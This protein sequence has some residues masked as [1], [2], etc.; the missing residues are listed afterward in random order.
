MSKSFEER[1]NIGLKLAGAFSIL[2]A[3]LMGIGFLGLRRMDQL[4]ANLDAVLGKR[5]AKLQ[6]AREA[7][8][9]STRNSRI[10]TTI[11]LV[12]DKQAI[13]LLR[14]ARA[15]NTGRI[16]EL[17]E[18]LAL[19]CDSEEEKHLLAV[20]NAERTSYVS[21]Y[22]RAL[23]LLVDERRFDAAR[24]IMV[25]EATPALFK[26]HD[27][28][29][30]FMQFEMDQMDRAAR[31]SR[32]RYKEIRAL[33]LLLIFLAVIVAA[34]IAVVMTRTSTREVRAR[35]LAQNDVKRLNSELEQRVVERTQQLAKAEEQVRRTLLQLQE[36]TAELEGV[37]DLLQLLQSC[38]TLEEYRAQVA[39]I[40]PR[41]FPRGALLML[42]TSHDLLDSAAEWGKL[43]LAQAHF[44]LRA[45]G[46]CV[47]VARIMRKQ[48]SPG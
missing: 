31:E 46:R 43:F 21:S 5:W 22:V 2:I 47:G 17:V 3:I 23:H 11:F 7:L 20:V 13:V 18:N 40:L 16:S 30:N 38:V 32:S 1:T 28:W 9:Y 19:Q 44:L 42:N 12:S 34:A 24:R 37:K 27:A 25:N 8:K 33:T 41:F 35:V 29:D 10:T 48:T 15:E 26:Y 6:L 4:N 45:V 14:N 39:R 36:Y